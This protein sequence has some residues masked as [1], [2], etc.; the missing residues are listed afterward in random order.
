MK[1]LKGILVIGVLII[2]FFFVFVIFLQSITTNKYI[3]YFERKL[4]KITNTYGIKWYDK[5]HYF[6][7]NTY[8]FHKP[9]SKDALLLDL[10]D[11]DVR[12]ND[13]IINIVTKREMDFPDNLKEW[14]KTHIIYNKKK[15]KIKYKFHGT[16]NR[17]YLHGKISLKI[18]SKKY[19]NDS[20]RF[21]LVTG[22]KE[23]SFVNIF[24]TLQA[25]KSK[26]IAPDPGSILLANLNGNLEDYW[27]TEDLSDNYLKNKY[28][29]E[30]F[31]IFKTNDDWSRNSGMHFSELDRFYYYL[32]NENLEKD[33]Q[34]Y[35]KYKAFRKAVNSNNR[36]DEFPNTNYQYMGRFLANLYF[37]Y[38]PHYITGDNNKYLYNYSNNIVYPV[39]RNEGTYRKISDL[40]NLDQGLFIYVQKSAT[41]DFYKKAV[42]NDSIKFY[43]DLELYRLVKNK[44]KTLHELDSLHKKY[45]NYHKYYN[46]DYRNVR[47][48]YKSI[49]GVV[50]HNSNALMKYLDNGEVI[51]AYDKKNKTIKI[52]T[53][54]RVPLKI[55]DIKNLESFVLKGVELKY[56]KGEIKSVLIE[57]EFTFKNTINKNQLKIVNM[58]TKDTIPSS[59]IIFNY[60]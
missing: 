32:S 9:S 37:Y 5:L 35:N 3:D 24:L 58:I 59:N 54:Y 40:L 42:C 51:I 29:L 8:G 23:S 43:R 20:K 15:L 53:D 2:S 18:K 7:V 50:N 45:D 36:K 56:E 52:A 28:G 48:Q 38:D 11:N 30:D 31:H 55:V 1:L 60:F 22:F 46:N 17:P 14:R 49:K 47:T 4:L 25:H 12:Y 57:N 21:S 39:A 13:S 16:H 10:S 33:S 27:F 19:I 6:D 41:Y 44:D 34:R 26:L